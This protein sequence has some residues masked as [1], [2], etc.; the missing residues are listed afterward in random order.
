M[1]RLDG[2]ALRLDFPCRFPRGHPSFA[3]GLEA[4]AVR[5]RRAPNVNRSWRPSVAVLVAALAVLGSVVT[6]AAPAAAGPADLKIN[7]VESN[8]G[9][10]GDWVELINNGSSPADVSGYVVKDN[11][12]TH[13]FTI[14]ASTTI[15]AGGYYVADVDP[16]FGLGAA[17]SARLFT[18]GAAALVDSYSWT[19]HAAVTYG[20]CPNGTGPFADTQASTRG[21]ANVCPGDVVA[22]PWPG[23]SAVSA[24]DG[25]NVFGTNLSG[26]AYQPSGSAARG[27]L[28]AVRNGPSTLY[29]LVYDGTKW[30][31]DTTNGWGAGKQLR[32]PDGTGDPDAEGVSLVGGD[33]AN[34]IYVSTERNNSA[35][36]ISRPEVLRFDASGSATSL[37]A[38]KEWNLTA[39]LPPLG[40]NLGL[41]AVAWVPD[42]FLLAKGFHDE[43]TGAPYAPATYADHGSGLFFVGAEQN[44]AIYAYALDQTSGNFTKVAT[45]ASG[46]PSVMDLELEP[47]SGHLWAECDDTCTGRSATLDIAPTGVNA[48]RFVVTNVYERPTG[49]PN[50]NN[51]GFAITP[52]QECVGGLKPVFWSDDAN[53]GSHALRTG[54]LDCTDP[55]AQTITFDPPSTVAFGADP[56]PLTATATSGLPVGLAAA[57]PCSITGTLGAPTLTVAGVGSCVITASQPGDVDTAPAPD[58]VR[59]VTITP[60]G[61]TLV[62]RPVSLVATVLALRVRHSAVLTSQVTGQ[63]LAGQPV[64]FHIT[65]TTGATCTAITDSAG[66]AACTSALPTIVRILAAGSTTARFAGTADYQPSSSTAPL[67]L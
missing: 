19:A 54:T 29:R 23:G 11:D 8:G 9:A 1:D 7:E 21:V 35:N 36:T 14:P 2:C 53:D 55:V 49:M 44:G 28:W 34:G 67:A 37:S 46:F 47:E 26:L 33:P 45:I 41:E 63:P 3:W 64:A 66:V 43:H 32:Y 24:A 13:V 18:P 61:T 16:L 4:S 10:P 52:R 6:T 5:E 38:T 59:T 62:E 39:D 42:S 17:D 27:V 51:E 20:R 25:V 22:L 48:G 30:T 57:G 58:V 12:D 15:A 56:V 65:G 60:A 40:A 50:F 31:P